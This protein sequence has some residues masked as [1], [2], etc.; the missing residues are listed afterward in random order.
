MIGELPASA[1]VPLALVDAHVSA[2][3]VIH[4]WA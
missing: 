4:K 3:Q 1:A 2:I